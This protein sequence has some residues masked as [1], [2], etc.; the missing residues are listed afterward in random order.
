MLETVA[1]ICTESWE[2]GGGV[3]DSRPPRP[4]S[5]SILLTL[6]P[7]LPHQ[8][9]PYTAGGGGH[10]AAKHFDIIYTVQR[11]NSFMKSTLTLYGNQSSVLVQS[12]HNTDASKN[13]QKH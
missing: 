13:L 8:S 11:V 10:L 1:A 3:Q 7:P 9:L 12:S 6:L 4:P 5:N 2:E